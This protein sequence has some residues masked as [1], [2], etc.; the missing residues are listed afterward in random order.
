[1][2]RTAPDPVPER[3]RILRIGPPAAPG[4]AGR[5][6]LR[7]L[8][9]LGTTDLDVETVQAPPLGRDVGEQLPH[10]VGGGPLAAAGRALVGA[11][12]VPARDPPAYA[13]NQQVTAD[14]DRDPRPLHRSRREPE[15]VDAELRAVVP[16]RATRPEPGE[17]LQ[18]LVE[19]LGQHPRRGR[20]AHGAKARGG[21]VTQA[22]AERQP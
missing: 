4:S 22:R 19:T 17:D 15:V 5:R 6:E 7:Q 16:D 8:G 14:P 20:L 13:G 2:R 12:A 10:V 11:A 21:R 9:G 1:P 3:L 18:A